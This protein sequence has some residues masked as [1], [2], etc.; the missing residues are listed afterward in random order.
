[1]LI[2]NYLCRFYI[3]N[4]IKWILKSL[5]H[6]ENIPKVSDS[7]YENVLNEAIERQWNIR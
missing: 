3:K 2:D 4:V 7:L 1:M 5:L 6:R